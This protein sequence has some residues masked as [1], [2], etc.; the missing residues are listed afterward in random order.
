[1]SSQSCG[2]VIDHPKGTPEWKAAK[3]RAKERQTERQT[4]RDALGQM[5][6][7]SATEGPAKAG[8]GKGVRPGG[9][10]GARARK[11]GGR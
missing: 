11:S 6:Q 7:I 2:L 1:M 9:K 5:L 10:G 3:E 4:D 8:G